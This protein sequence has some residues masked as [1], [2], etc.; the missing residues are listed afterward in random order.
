MERRLSQPVEVQAS[1]SHSS[2]GPGLPGA[3]ILGLNAHTA[4][5]GASR[6]QSRESPVPTSP[7]E[8]EQVLRE[9][10][11]LTRQSRL[12]SLPQGSPT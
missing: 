8:W 11:R 1:E 12:L 3:A 5:L 9:A 2:S 10:P 4:W 6:L 7:S